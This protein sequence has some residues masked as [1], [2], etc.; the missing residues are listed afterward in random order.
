MY[1]MQQKSAKPLENAT[2]NA[3][4]WSESKCLPTSGECS[5]C[6]MGVVPV[7]RQSLSRKR[8]LEPGM[9]NC[10]WTACVYSNASWWFNGVLLT[11]FWFWAS[12]TSSSHLLQATWSTKHSGPSFTNDAWKESNPWSLAACPVRQKPSILALP[13]ALCWMDRKKTASCVNLLILLR[14]AAKA[15][16]SKACIWNAI[17]LIWTSFD[18]GTQQF[19]NNIKT[20]QHFF[21]FKHVQNV[22][23]IWHCEREM[24]VVSSLKRSPLAVNDAV[25]QRYCWAVDC[26]RFAG[27]NAKFKPWVKRDAF[28]SGTMLEPG[29]SHRKLHASMHIRC[30]NERS[31]TCICR[32]L[33]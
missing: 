17:A 20:I 30:V 7:R 18:W 29:S 13:G 2:T 27:S 10:V 3:E 23:N 33:G 25:M 4:T 15:S 6:Q 22:S 1:D 26:G 9:I 21:L 24:F 14:S 19:E 32:T 12:F 31:D 28:G 16:P 5:S 8:N 11:L